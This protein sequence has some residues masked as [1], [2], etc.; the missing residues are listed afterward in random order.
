M[1]YY[2]RFSPTSIKYYQ[3]ITL[4]K[5]KLPVSKKLKYRIRL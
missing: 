4:T 2:R 3:I 5:G 1:Y